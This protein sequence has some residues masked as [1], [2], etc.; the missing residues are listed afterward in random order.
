MGKAQSKPR[1]QLEVHAGDLPQA[2]AE[3]VADSVK[4]KPKD[5]LTLWK[6]NQSSST[7]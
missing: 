7:C 3:T 6:V 2:V 1:R 4:N 5:E